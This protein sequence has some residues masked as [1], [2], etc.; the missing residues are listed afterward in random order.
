MPRL[1]RAETFGFGVAILI[2][3][4]MGIIVF[5]GPYHKINKTQAAS[6]FPTLT[7]KI[8]NNSK[9]IGQYVPATIHVHAGQSV[10]FDNVS[11]VAHTVTARDNSFD[12]RNVATGESWKNTFTQKGT[13]PYYCIYHPLMKGTVVVTS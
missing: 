11:A 13:F 10:I 4:I 3:I 6:S 1:S 9:T 12:S 5:T 8:I 7:V 2:V